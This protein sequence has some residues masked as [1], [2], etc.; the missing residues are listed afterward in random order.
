MTEPS[1]HK[2]APGKWFGAISTPELGSALFLYFL[3][4]NPC[5]KLAGQAAEHSSLDYHTT[6][7]RQVFLRLFTG[8]GMKTEY[9]FY[10]F[11]Y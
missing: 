4:R 5:N 7:T 6:V 2:L 3:A 1:R 8:R 9:Y 11:T 10:T